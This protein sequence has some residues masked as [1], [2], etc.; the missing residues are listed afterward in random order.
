MWWKIG[1]AVRQLFKFS[2]EVVALRDLC[3]RVF[4][5]ARALFFPEMSKKVFHFTNE[6][7]SFVISYFQNFWTFSIYWEHHYDGT[8]PLYRC[9]GIWINI[10]VCKIIIS[11]I[12]FCI[13]KWCVQIYQDYFTVMGS[14]IAE[15]NTN[16][17]SIK[18]VCWSQSLYYVFLVLGDRYLSRWVHNILHSFEIT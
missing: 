3:K 11:V 4:L 18:A 6:H 8:I 1:L 10:G 5:L 7:T 13:V 15:F 9:R 12:V 17:T 2:A 14:V 16:L